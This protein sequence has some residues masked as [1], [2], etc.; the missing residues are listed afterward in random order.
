MVRVSCGVR[1]RGPLHDY[2]LRAWTEVEL[3]QLDAVERIADLGE[4]ARVLRSLLDEDPGAVLGLRRLAN[5]VLHGWSRIDDG[6][7]VEQLAGAVARGS[8]LLT[9]KRRPIRGS[10]TVTRVD[11]YE[12]PPLEP[13][14]ELEVFLRVYSEAD[15]WPTLTVESRSE[16]WP[17]LSSG[18]E[19]EELEFSAG[20][21]I[22]ELGF[23]VG[24]KPRVSAPP[25]AATR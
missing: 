6:E 23:S 5:E 24:E 14:E 10:D 18:D 7:L 3:A 19:V 4:A 21:E 25:E 11:L 12:P 22:E 15:D 8:L 20:G 16:E 17:T 9:R 2:E 1:L 13:Y